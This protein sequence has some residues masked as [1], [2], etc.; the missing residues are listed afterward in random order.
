MAI[1]SEFEETVLIFPYWWYDRF[2]LNSIHEDE[3]K[4][5]FRYEK[6]DIPRF[7][8]AFCLPPKCV[9]SSGTTASAV[10][11]LCILL[12]RFFLPLPIQ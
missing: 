11:G 12:K 1:A 6:V 10:E 8:K 5:K 2:D 7:P 9:C 3:C 4:T